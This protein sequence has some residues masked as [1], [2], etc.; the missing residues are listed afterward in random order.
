MLFA[1]WDHPKQC[2]VRAILCLLYMLKWKS[3][4]LFPSREEIAAAQRDKDFDG[5]YTSHLPYKTFLEELQT[6]LRLAVPRLGRWGVHTLRYVCLA[7]NLTNRKTYY[8]LAVWGGGA[9]SVIMDGARHLSTKN[10]RK[11]EKGATLAKE[12]CD[13]DPEMLDYNAVVPRWKATFVAD[14]QM[15]GALNRPHIYGSID[16][17]ATH[18]VE[19]LLTLPPGQMTVSGIVEASLSFRRE[20]SA[21]ETLTSLI[22]KLNLPVEE[23]SALKT[24]VEEYSLSKRYEGQ[25]VERRDEVLGDGEVED[26]AVASSSRSKGKRVYGTFDNAQRYELRKMKSGKDMLRKMLAICS[27]PNI[28]E[29]HEDGTS[30]WK[31]WIINA[32]KLVSCYTGCFGGKE[33]LFLAKYSPNDAKINYSG[34][35]CKCVVE[36]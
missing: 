10:A 5:N 8:L 3:G 34:W 15:I 19:E 28:P 11:Y 26:L 1:E 2:P 35:K 13:Q 12:Y 33:A 18:F 17:V 24:A 32:R 20:T 6:A 16:Q 21:L 29:S 14:C 9:L 25:V 23:S 22:S 30:G 4:H 27:D 7:V 36:E 31:G